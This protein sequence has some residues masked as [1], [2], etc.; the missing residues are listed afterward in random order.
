V[1]ALSRRCSLFDLRPGDVYGA[2]RPL[3]VQRERL[4]PGIVFHCQRTRPHA[5][6]PRWMLVSPEHLDYE[7]HRLCHAEFFTHAPVG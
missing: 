2:R 3:S 1:R 7:T 6:T 4:T 5:F